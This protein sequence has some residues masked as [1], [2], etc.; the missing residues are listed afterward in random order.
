[1]NYDDLEKTSMIEVLKLE[2]TN[3]SAVGDAK[4][5]MAI[6]VKCSL[7]IGKRLD[8]ATKEIENFNSST[9]KL[10]K[11]LLWLNGILAIATVVGA[12]ATLEMAG[13]F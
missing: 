11:R 8:D 2:D 10:N 4:G 5:I 9:T 12:Y 13:I 3:L 7:E 6:F 1:M